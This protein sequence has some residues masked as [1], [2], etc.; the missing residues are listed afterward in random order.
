[1]NHPKEFAEQLEEEACLNTLI[2]ENLAKVEMPDEEDDFNF[3]TRFMEPKR[4]LL[5]ELEEEKQLSSEIVRNL[6]KVILV[7]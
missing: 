1:M 4:Q 3:A 5:S 7:E 2:L 6:S